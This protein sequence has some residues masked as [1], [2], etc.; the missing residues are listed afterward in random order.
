MTSADLTPIYTRLLAEQ[1]EPIVADP[2]AAHTHAT[3]A[4]TTGISTPGTADRE[5]S[6][7]T[8]PGLEHDAR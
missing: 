1:G 6:P 8:T 5:L 3:S 2:P 4:M 7:A